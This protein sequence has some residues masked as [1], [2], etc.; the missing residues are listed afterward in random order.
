MNISGGD[1]P[2][3]ELHDE[4]W[5]E[6]WER[7]QDSDDDSGHISQLLDSNFMPLEVSL[8]NTRSLCR[9]SHHTW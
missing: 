9:N 6:E 4:G 7:Y 1:D 8:H 5:I 2:E 3:T